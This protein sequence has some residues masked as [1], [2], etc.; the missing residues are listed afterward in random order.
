[1]FLLTCHLPLKKYVCSRLTLLPV[2]VLCSCSFK[3]AA[4][5]NEFKQW[6]LDALQSEQVKESSVFPAGSFPSYRRYALNGNTEKAD[7]NPFFTGLI[8][9]TLLG[10]APY[11]D[12]AQQQQAA[13][14]RKRCQQTYIKFA[15]KSGRPTYNFWPTDTP[16]IFPNSGWLNWF[17]K[18]QA[19]P[20]DADDTVIL[21]LSQQTTDSVAQ[22]VHQLLR[23]YAN[24]QTQQVRNTYAG[25]RQLPA[26][27]TWFGKK[28]PV[29]FDVCVLTNIL[30]FV[31]HHRLPWNDADSASLQLITQV[32]ANDSYLK[33]PAYVSPHYQ[34][35][36]VILYHLARLMQLRPIPALE[37]FKEKLVQEAS[38]Q[39]ATTT[40]FMDAVLLHTAL[41]RWGIIP[42]ARDAIRFDV[43]EKQL[44]NEPFSFFVANMSSMLPGKLKS[45]L[46]RAAIGK[47]YYNCPGYHYAL[48][49]ENM[50]W[51]DIRKKELLSSQID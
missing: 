2:V 42:P 41:L 19:L 18:R 39:L 45:S 31:Q 33:E 3:A 30:Y 23:Q 9:F 6:L 25:L 14:I 11:L 46:D 12:P 44:R 15:N 32:V 1:M 27:S 5:Q 20:D 48:V 49:L 37:Q 28:M 51:Q 4:Q 43:W 10:I 22:Q 7:I 38:R 16:T 47:F 36:P 50:I 40:H 34:R 26:Y 35:V 21:L 8:D 24:G 13:V 17:N 29:D